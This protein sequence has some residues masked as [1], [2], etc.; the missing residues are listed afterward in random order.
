MMF[1]DR[2][3]SVSELRGKN[4]TYENIKKAVLKAGRF[5]VF[6]VK[7]KEDKILFTRLCN[8]PDLEI[9]K[10]EYPW[11]YVRS[12][13]NIPISSKLYLEGKAIKWCADNDRTSSPFNVISALCAMG[14]IKE[15]VRQYQLL[16]GKWKAQADKT[17]DEREQMWLYAC[18]SDLESLIRQSH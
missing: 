14:W 9:Y 17:A 18:A 3:D 16:V 11:T 15:E 6:D 10:K 7:T 13:N 1:L 8:D 2:F 4:R 12:R 5:S